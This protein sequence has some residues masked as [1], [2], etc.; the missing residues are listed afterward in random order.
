MGLWSSRFQQE[1]WTKFEMKIIMIMLLLAVQIARL[2]A[3]AT[4]CDI[5]GGWS[6]PYTKGWFQ[7]IDCDADGIPDPTC[8][9]NDGTF[10]IVSSAHNCKLLGPDVSCK[11]Q[12]DLQ[13]K[14]GPF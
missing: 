1:D 14:S 8:T 3:D 2:Q 6:C 9:G 5:P 4:V 12:V 13:K 10:W 7:L 11:V